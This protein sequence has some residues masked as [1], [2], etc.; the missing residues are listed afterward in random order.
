MGRG[1]IVI[2]KI[3]N[4]TSRQ[5][6]FSKRRNGLIK[7]AKELS[8]LCDAEVGLIVF[9][10]TDKLYE[11]SSTRLNTLR[12]D[13]HRSILRMNSLLERYDTSKE[14]NPLMNASTEAKFW[15]REAATLRHQF[16]NL[17]EGYWQMMGQELCSLSANELQNLE[18]QLELSLRGVHMQKDQLL[19]DEIRKLNQ[20]RNLLRQENM[21]LFNKEHHTRQ[22][23]LDLL[24]KINEARDANETD[25]MSH[26]PNG[27]NLEEDIKVQ[28]S[29]P[30]QQ[31]CDT[32]RGEKA[33]TLS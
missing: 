8:I 24:R 26:S 11:F 3:D 31:N 5:V 9:S 29:Q 23:N 18:N 27:F 17:Q 19:T 28:L 32:P 15:K 25:R 10:S 14:E 22:E 30:Q 20:K 4:I 13:Q 7:K 6:T 12:S 2:Q 16:Q 21:E 1:K 33:T